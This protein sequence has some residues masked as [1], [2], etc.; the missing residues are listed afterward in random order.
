MKR[1]RNYFSFCHLKRGQPSKNIVKNSVDD[2]KY[3]SVGVNESTVCP[4]RQ[5]FNEK[6]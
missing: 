2:L 5:I 3:G 4:S 1:F 6:C